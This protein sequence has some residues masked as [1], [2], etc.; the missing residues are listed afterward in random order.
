MGYSFHVTN[1]TGFIIKTQCSNFDMPF[2]ASSLYYEVGITV[3]LHSR[4]TLCLQLTLIQIGER[5]ETHKQFTEII[6]DV[7]LPIVEGMDTDPI[8]PQ[9]RQKVI[10]LVHISAEPV[11]ALDEQDV[12]I[13]FVYR[14]HHTDE[15]GPLHIQAVAEIGG[16][17]RHFVAFLGGEVQQFL[18]LCLEA[19]VGVL[20]GVNSCVEPASFFFCHFYVRLSRISFYNCP[21]G[22]R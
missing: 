17:A 12:E 21:Q 19:P 6:V 10:D 3:I 11:N 14:L 5:F 15:A 8:D 9:L 7:Q 20:R 4:A 2:A 18:F 16:G 13:P 22:P 1:F